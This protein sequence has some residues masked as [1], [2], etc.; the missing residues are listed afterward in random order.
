MADTLTGT[1]N[2]KKGV[3]VFVG[4]ITE[5]DVVGGSVICNLPDEVYVTKA[6]IDVVTPSSTTSATVDL[7]VGSA[8]VADECD[9]TTAGYSAGTNAPAKFAN[10]GQIKAVA[11]ATAPAAGDLTCTVYVE[12]IEYS[13]ALGELTDY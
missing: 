13:R 6:F 8:V 11:G 9:A 10:G 12:Y 7:Q 3:R 4:D 2:E 1:F 5:A